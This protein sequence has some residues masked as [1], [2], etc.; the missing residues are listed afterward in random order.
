[1]SSHFSV[2]MLQVILV[3]SCTRA[4]EN[5][6][7]RNLPGTPAFFKSPVPTSGTLHAGKLPRQSAQSLYLPSWRDSAAPPG[8]FFGIFM[9]PPIS[10][11]SPL[12]ER[13]LAGGTEPDG[14]GIWDPGN[15][16]VPGGSGYGVY[17]SEVMAH[18]AGG[19]GAADEYIEICNPR[20]T[21]DLGTRLLATPGG[22]RQSPG[23]PGTGHSLIPGRDPPGSRR[24]RP[25]HRPRLHPDAIATGCP[26]HR[27]RQAGS[28]R[29]IDGS[30][31]RTRTAQ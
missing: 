8:R 13:A 17:I 30:S 31:S 11:T 22:K 24:N 20:E 25:D 5:N 18:P 26:P 1:M 7:V 23:S 4:P 21:I 29:T 27:T 14:P 10:R 2:R 3:F 15:I 28:I 6:V 9:A 16:L 19:G 12:M